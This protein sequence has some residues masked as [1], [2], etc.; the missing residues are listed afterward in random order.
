M[1]T[2]SLLLMTCMF[3][4]SVTMGDLCKSFLWIMTLL[5]EGDH[6]PFKFWTDFFFWKFLIILAF[7]LELI[8]SFFDLDN[9]LLI[10]V[11]FF[12]FFLL[13]LVCNKWNYINFSFNSFLIS[14][15]SAQFIFL[16]LQFVFL[17]I[18]LLSSVFFFSALTFLEHL[19][20]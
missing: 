15:I 3:W 8:L 9:P 12:R 10:G 6:L 20:N 2:I 5:A 7:F 18:L 1:E 17:T 4:S 13:F 16:F 14:E 11:E 19:F